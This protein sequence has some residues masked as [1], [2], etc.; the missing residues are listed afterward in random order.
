MFGRR[1]REQQER[2]RRI[3]SREA[4]ADAE[5]RAV[6]IA[7]LQVRENFAKMRQ[8]EPRLVSNV[9]VTRLDT[10]VKVDGTLA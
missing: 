10:D 5:E 9:V 6:K 3:R 1:E 7:T 4:W 2:A 8:D